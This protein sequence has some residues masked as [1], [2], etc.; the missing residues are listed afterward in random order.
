MFRNRFYSSLIGMAVVM[1]LFASAPVIGQESSRSI[2]IN[3]EAKLG[4]QVLAK[5]SYNIKYTEGKD[6]EIVFV[7]GKQDVLKIAYKWSKLDATPSDTSVIY[8]LADDGSYRI[9]R[10]EIKGKEYA[11]ALE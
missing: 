4:G 2:T 10:I 6:G 8:A 7:K 11:L 5:G 1:G 9:K 3:R